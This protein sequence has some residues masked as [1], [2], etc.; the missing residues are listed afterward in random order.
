MPVATEA[1]LKRKQMLGLLGEVEAAPD[2]AGSLYL[3]PNTPSGEIAKLA[4]KIPGLEPAMTDL[5]PYLGSHSGAVIFWGEP[6]RLL[7]LPPFPV[8]E[9]VIFTGYFTEPLRVMLET[10]FTI[11]L[12]LLRLGAY[13]VGVFQGE[14][15][16]SSKV[17]TGLVHAR[18]RQG[19]SSAARFRRHRE[20]Q[21]ET[22]FTRV[23]GHLREHFEPYLGKIDYVVYGGEKFTL[24]SFQ[25]QC[26]F[27]GQLAGLTLPYRLDI[28]HPKQAALDMAIEQVW[29]SRVIFW[30]P[31]D[32]LPAAQVN[33]C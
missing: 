16:V 31:P 19:G 1:R 14:K 2:G 24:S 27:S 3:P 11:G 20:K 21:A 30:Q 23:C 12:L 7:V 4:A 15:L 5:L 26:A 13:A 8:K 33:Q 32:F 18:H 6:H 17:G 10:E 22:F 9:K 28:R 25:K 29:T